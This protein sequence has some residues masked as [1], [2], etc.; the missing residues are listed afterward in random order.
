MLCPQRERLMS[1]YHDAV[2]AFE[3][4]V[5]RLRHLHDSDFVRVY[6]ESE[7]LRQACD[8]ARKR[9]EQHVSEH[10]CGGPAPSGGLKPVLV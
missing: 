5:E 2:R 4:C 7:T 8:Q 9:L 10:A 6:Q 3:G 1:A